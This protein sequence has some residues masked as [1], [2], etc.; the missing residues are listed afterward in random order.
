MA[1]EKKTL[2]PAGKLIIYADGGARGNPGPAAIGVVI[3]SRKYGER[4]GETT[5]N[6]AE[7][8]ALLFALQKAKQLLSKRQA[9]TTELEVRMDSELVVKQLNGQYKILEPELQ[10]FF[11]QIWNLKLDFKHVEFIHIPREENRE[12]DR[13]VNLAL[14]GK[15]REPRLRRGFGGRGGGLLGAMMM[16]A[17]SGAPLSAVPQK[18]AVPDLLEIRVATPIV[19]SLPTI[20]RMAA[21]PS[22]FRAIAVWKLPPPPPVASVNTQNFGTAHVRPQLPPVGREK[23]SSLIANPL[24]LTK[25]LL[26]NILFYSR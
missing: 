22:G 13:M 10:G 14:D 20:P 21:L 12:A 17:L 23:I 18:T 7:Y 8:K 5:N 1:G 26:E 15:M 4:I 9:K 11:L 16:F 6:V 2:F 25:P 24:E 19:F 3:G